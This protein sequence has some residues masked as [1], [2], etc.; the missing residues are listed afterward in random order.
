MPGNYPP[1]FQIKRILVWFQAKISKRCLNVELVKSIPNQTFRTASL[2]TTKCQRYLHT[3]LQTNGGSGQRLYPIIH[4]KETKQLPKFL[5][6]V[7]I[8]LQLS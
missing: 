5:N 7:T 8:Q 4:C 6:Q 1:F 3:A 2:K